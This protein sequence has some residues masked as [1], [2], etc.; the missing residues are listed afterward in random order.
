[1][2]AISQLEKRI[3]SIIKLV[4]DSLLE[5]ETLMNDYSLLYEGYKL[6]RSD[7]EQEVEN[8][9]RFYSIIRGLAE[10]LGLEEWTTENILEKAK[11]KFQ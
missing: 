2:D 6:L 1:M 4:E 7:H 5:R 10:I 9:E 3:D 11:A 8:S